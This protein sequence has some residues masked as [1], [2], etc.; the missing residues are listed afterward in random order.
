MII[1][2]SW[3]SP[4]KNC[5][6]LNSLVSISGV[7]VLWNIKAPLWLFNTSITTAP[8]ERQ[9]SLAFLV[10]FICN[11]R[12]FSSASTHLLARAFCWTC[13]VWEL[14]LKTAIRFIHSALVMFWSIFLKISK[15]WDYPKKKQVRFS[16][17]LIMKISVIFNLKYFQPTI[18]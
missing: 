2:T 9:Y 8:C 13:F 12:A 16:G 1:L 18:K 14:I 11:C 15:H 4:K 6:F 17:M 5:L 3:S 7:I 10:P